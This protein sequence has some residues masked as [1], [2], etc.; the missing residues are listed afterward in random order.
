MSTWA[1]TSSGDMLLPSI[2]QGATAIITD[3]DQ[4]AAIRI[5]DGL[6]M[7][8]GNWLLDTSQGMA[9]SQQVLG[10]KNPPLVAISNLIRKAILTL[11][12]PV[13]IAVTQLNIAF[14][15]SARDLKYSFQAASNTGATIIG[16]T[17]GPAG[18][19]FVVVQ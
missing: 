11:G 18:Q 9:W 8:L 7:F 14:F 15:R 13:V 10:K 12:S 2:G 6:L 4:C 1:R 16:G 17:A 3:P 19:V 5:Q